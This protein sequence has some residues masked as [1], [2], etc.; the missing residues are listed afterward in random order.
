MKK[1][2]HRADSRGFLD[3][4][5]L[6]TY[7]SFSFASYYDPEKIHFGTLRV[8]NDDYIDPA[9]GFGTHPHNDMEIITI[10]LSGVVAHRDNT[11]HEEFIRP[12]D[13]QVMSAGSGIF[14]SEFNGSEEEALNLL[15][16]W[17][18]P[19]AKGHEPRYNQKTFDPELRKGK[20]HTF[21]SPEKEG[22]NL[23][24]NQN[25][26]FSWIELN[27]DSQITYK[28]NDPN[29]GVYIFTIEGKIEAA[30]EQLMKRDGMGI[31][32]VEGFEMSALSSSFILF[33][34]VPV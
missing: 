12:N 18:F 15:Q 17:V 8:L 33:M 2:L 1:K 22:E 26:Y 3:H 4:G 11:G 30:G 16:I 13:V 6:R 7:H 9:Q 29:N 24:L 25:A 23:W 32:G 34:E 14:H 27:A 5:W 28:L 21:I 10:P 31:S 20:L 19:N